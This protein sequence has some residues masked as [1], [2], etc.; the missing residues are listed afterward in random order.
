MLIK[1]IMTEDFAA[2]ERNET[3]DRAVRAMLRDDVNHVVVEEGET[4]SAI[5]TRRKVLHACYQTDSPLSEIPVSGFDRG[6]EAMIEPNTTA[7]LAVGRIQNSEVSCLPVVDEMEVL[8]ILTKDDII[9][10]VSNITSDT[11][12]RDDRRS[13]WTDA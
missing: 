12:R 13:E 7:L 8:G 1:E 3:L 2:V 9:D 6:F 10:N 5:I 11:L 4:P